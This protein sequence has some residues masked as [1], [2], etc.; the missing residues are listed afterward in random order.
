M[1]LGVG[2]DEHSAR[3]EIAKDPRNPATQADL[4]AQY[5][6]GLRVWNRLSDLS[7][8]VNTIR[9]LKRQLERWVPKDGEAPE[10]DEVATGATALR[11]ALREVE[12]DLVPT[13]TKGSARL[14]NPDKLDGKL[15]VLLQ[16]AAFPARPT[17]AS[18][19]VAGELSGQMDGLLARLDALL[20]GPV[21]EFNQLVRRV[22]MPALAARP[23]AAREG[24]AAAAPGAGDPVES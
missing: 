15:R 9:E 7:G 17:D 10:G 13:D 19:A 4:D 16:Q 3:F 23:S 8:A 1:R 18:L 14:S 21:E 24:A 2:A 22:G 11:D 5:A 6:H 12:R 20:E